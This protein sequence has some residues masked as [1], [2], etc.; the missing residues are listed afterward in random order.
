MI[1]VLG[2]GL[3]T[4]TECI[5]SFL[6]CLVEM[7]FHSNLCS[8]KYAA[9]YFNYVEGV[10]TP[11]KIVFTYRF[12]SLC[13]ALAMSAFNTFLGTVTSTRKVFQMTQ[14]SKYVFYLIQT[15]NNIVH[16]VVF[17]YR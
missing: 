17:I 2:K 7:I 3:L 14:T 1:A 15:G 12:M 16:R 4:S 11:F 10:I 6:L 8:Y 5:L 9:A 13:Y